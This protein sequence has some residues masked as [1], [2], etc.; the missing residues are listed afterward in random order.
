MSKTDA[1][2]NFVL[3]YKKTDYGKCEHVCAMQQYD[4]DSRMSAELVQLQY[5]AVDRLCAAFKPLADGM[6]LRFYP[7]GG[8]LFQAFLPRSTSE[9]IKTNDVDGFLV[10]IPDTVTLSDCLTVQKEQKQR[11]VERVVSVYKK[12]YANI[13]TRQKLARWLKDASTAQSTFRCEPFMS[14]YNTENASEHSLT[15]TWDKKRVTGQILDEGNTVFAQSLPLTLDFLGGGSVQLD[16]HFGVLQPI[17]DQKTAKVCEIVASARRWP[18]YHHTYA[19]S[20]QTFFIDQC[21][22][23]MES[24]SLLYQY[25]ILDPKAG[26]AKEHHK[27]VARLMKSQGIRQS[28]VKVKKR[29]KRV[30]ELVRTVDVIASSRLQDFYAA[31]KADVF[32]SVPEVKS[33]LQTSRL[34]K[35]VREFNQYFLWGYHKDKIKKIQDNIG[36]EEATRSELAKALRQPLRDMMAALHVREGNDL[37]SVYVLDDDVTARE[38]MHLV[39]FMFERLQDQID[40]TMRGVRKIQDVSRTRSTTSRLAAA[41]RKNAAD[42]AEQKTAHPQF[43]QELRAFKLASNMKLRF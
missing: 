17:C 34:E 33:F 41:Q 36:V 23:L 3:V 38:M 25:L 24:L 21:R 10:V 19:Q 14:K 7:Y 5:A 26:S 28:F 11:V 9:Y 13:F 12:L 15:A 1:S 40:S 16:V 22:T 31:H 37:S 43:A 32:S 42:G 18:G 4:T 29:M 8:S 27:K 6:T 20:V 39:T 35:A 30:G 2:S